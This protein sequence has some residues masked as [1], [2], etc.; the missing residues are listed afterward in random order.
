MCRQGSRQ[1]VLLDADGI[2]QRQTC[3][4]YRMDDQ[5][6]PMKNCSSCLSPYPFFSILFRRTTSSLTLTR[7]TASGPVT[8]LLAPPSRAMSA[9]LQTIS[10][11][12]AS[13]RSR[14]LLPQTPLLSFSGR[15]GS[16]SVPIMHAR[17]LVSFA[18]DGNRTTPRCRL[19]NGE[20]TCC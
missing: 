14:L 9:P 13:S 4:R 15:F 12:V 6:A 3:R 20:A 10:K 5:G 8:S 1:C 16:A 11:P 7:R 17:E 18:V 19:W 2:H